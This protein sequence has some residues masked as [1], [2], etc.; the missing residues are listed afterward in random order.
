VTLWFDTEDYLEPASDEA[1][2]RIAEDL[3][4]LGV[5][6]TFK[7]VAEK[8]RTLEKRGRRDVIKA[9]SKHD[10][11]Y[12]TQFHSIPPAPAVYLEETGYLEGAQE[13][14]RR[15]AQGVADVRRIFAKAPSCYGQPGS[16]WGPQANRALRELGIPVYLD[17]GEQVGVDNQP[18]WYGGLLYIFNMGP[19]TLRASLQEGRR[20]EDD[21]ARFDAAASELSSKGGGVI[22]IY[23]HP[24]EFVTTEFWDGVNFSGGA[25]PP[26]S[27]WK[28]PR[29]RTRDDAERCY[30][31]LTGLVRHILGNRQARF[32]TARQL[33]DLYSPGDAPP[34]ERRRAAEH[35]VS[36]Q[37]FLQNEEGAWSAA[38][39]LLAL[40][41]LAAQFVE[42]P[43]AAKA[44]TYRGKTIESEAFER[45]RRE[46]VSYIRQHARLPALVWIG[47]EHLSLV[48]FAA[49][50]AGADSPPA[51]VIVRA[52]NPE[53]DRYFATDS[54]RPFGWVIHPPGFSGDNLLC[55]GRLQGWTLKPARLRPRGARR[56]VVV[57]SVLTPTR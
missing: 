19:F 26:R 42:G 41:G 50:L 52:G 37:I 13:F 22:S 14:R 35:L 21:L 53:F 12:H 46:A 1:A 18:F 3:S 24:C 28:L 56:N 48:D 11:G 2:L 40:L 57:K 7:V 29:K 55:L 9:L 34:I 36:R 23:Y 16:S 38:D 15:E 27:Q 32:V 43:L 4:R 54:R 17:E 5:E 20:L 30:R 31:V 8:A 51:E 6:A 25:D 45:A 49:T 47:S 44:S 33:S 39:L 10:I